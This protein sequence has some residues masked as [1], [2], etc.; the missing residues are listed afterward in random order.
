[1]DRERTLWMVYRDVA[2]EPTPSGHYPVS[3]KYWVGFQRRQNKTASHAAEVHAEK[4]ILILNN[5]WN[6]NF[7]PYET[8]GQGQDKNLKARTLSEVK[9]VVQED[10]VKPLSHT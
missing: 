3:N 10:L 6:Q 9:A 8:K 2:A 4:K 7:S 1:M 5:T